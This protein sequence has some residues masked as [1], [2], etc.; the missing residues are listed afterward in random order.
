MGRGGA[1]SGGGAGPRY[2]GGVGARL[3]RRGHRVWAEPD[4]SRIDKQYT[5]NV[6]VNG[7]W[8]DGAAHFYDS[9]EEYL[10]PLDN[11]RTSTSSVSL[12][13]G[14]ENGRRLSSDRARLS[15]DMGLLDGCAVN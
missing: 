2:G 10:T 14:C 12:D 9:R 15:F 4:L 1:A 8:M 11:A 7:R 6:V 13:R 5:V 3:E